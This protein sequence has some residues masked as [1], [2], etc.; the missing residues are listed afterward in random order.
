MPVNPR[1][2]EQIIAWTNA[3][4]QQK[5]DAESQRQHKTYVDLHLDDWAFSETSSA[6]KVQHS[7]RPKTASVVDFAFL[8]PSSGAIQSVTCVRR[9]TAIRLEHSRRFHLSANW[10]NSNFSTGEV[11]DEVPSE[12]GS[13][14]SRAPTRISAGRSTGETGNWKTCLLHLCRASFR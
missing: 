9:P 7:R 10:T 12:V 3:E 13:T 2:M 14:P 8:R 11:R 6:V 4:A 5:Y 1:G